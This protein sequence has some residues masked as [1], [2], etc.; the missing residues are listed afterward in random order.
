MAK[1]KQTKATKSV[2]TKISDGEAQ[3]LAAYRAQAQ[4]VAQ[5]AQGMFDAKVAQIATEG[6]KLEQREDGI[7]R[8]P[9]TEA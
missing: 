5:Q 6:M 9:V 8:V 2:G 3:D 4:L 7:Y 1:R